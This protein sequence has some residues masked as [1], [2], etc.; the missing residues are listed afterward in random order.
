MTRKVYGGAPSPSFF[1]SKQRSR[2]ISE[3]SLYHFKRSIE[4]STM[5]N[6]S[7][8]KNVTCVSLVSKIFC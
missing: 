6:C 8:S 3:T 4:G 1:I 7:E 5:I 2:A